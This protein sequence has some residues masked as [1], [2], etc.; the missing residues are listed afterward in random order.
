MA[1]YK[2]EMVKPNRLGSHSV[3]FNTASEEQEQ[4][5]I[6]RRFEFLMV[7]AGAQLHESYWR[8]DE[9]PN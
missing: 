4:K 7:T 5:R 8:A 9:F 1:I 2:A 3:P 6:Y